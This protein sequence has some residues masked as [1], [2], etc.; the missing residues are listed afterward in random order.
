MNTTQQPEALRLAEL[1]DN[2]QK[3]EKIGTELRRQ[4][5]RIAELEGLGGGLKFGDVEVELVEAESPGD[6]VRSIRDYLGVHDGIKLG[7]HAMDDMALDLAR[8]ALRFQHLV[9]PPADPMDWPLPCDVTVG[10]GTMRKG[11]ALR[12]L[13]LRMKGLYEMATGQNA[14]EVA[15]RTPEQ[16]AELL[17]AFQAKIAPQAVQAAAHPAEGAT[18][19]AVKLLAADH[20]GMK[21]DYRGLFSQVQRALKRTDPGHAEMLRQL[22]GH[23]QELGQ[24]WYAGDTAVVDELL[25]LY[26]VECQ[27]R[28]ALAAQ[29][30]QEQST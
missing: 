1:C 16:R 8:I 9:A 14:D 21:V 30:E 29:A 25:Q 6:L 20:S 28:D 2:F 23:L 19:Q 22:E 27:A 11:V 13:V 15:A 12:T 5:A 10:H 24:R 4:H 26:S 17:S 18:A 7:G 3:L